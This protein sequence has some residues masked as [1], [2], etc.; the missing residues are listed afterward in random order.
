MTN[1]YNYLGN[2]GSFVPVLCAE[3]PVS[4][5]RLSKNEAEN[6]SDRIIKEICEVEDLEPK[7]INKFIKNKKCTCAYF[8]TS[9]QLSISHHIKYL[10]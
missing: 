10:K 3:E 7:T 8:I 5:A 6:S 2:D 4:K 9:I 1:F